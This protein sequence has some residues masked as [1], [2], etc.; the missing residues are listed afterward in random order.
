MSYTQITQEERYLIHAQMRQGIRPAQIG[1][2]LNRHPSSISRELKRNIHHPDFPRYLPGIAHEHAGGRRS[3]SRKG[4]HFSPMDW[5][6]VCVQLRLDW[7]P[8]QIALVF[9]RDGILRISHET[10]YRYVW[11]DKHLG[12]DLYRHLRQSPKQRRKRYRTHDSRGILRG[13][14]DITERPAAAEQRRT[15]GHAEG[16]LVFGAKARDCILTV[17]DRKSRFLVIRKL[18]DKTMG[19]V[20]RAL[21]HVI[22]QYG[23]RTLTLDNG[24]EFHDYARVERLTGARFYFAKPYHAWERGTS[25][26]TNGLIRQYLP[27]H[28]SMAQ[29][30]QW[31]CNAIA[32]KLNRRPRKVLNLRTPEDTHTA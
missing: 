5:E 31:E 12:G 27:K 23:I 22:R 29:L 3:R 6:L 16:D 17:V 11:R 4:L 32:R 30:T 14:R 21:I 25:E 10:I 18:K 7:S 9:R 15:L 1:R 2:N 13:K 26:N 19:P 28:L 24:S 8:E 20:S